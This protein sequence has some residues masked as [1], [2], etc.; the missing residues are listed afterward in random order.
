[1]SSSSA[2]RPRSLAVKARK[3]SSFSEIQ[4]GYSQL[5]S[6]SN[7]SILGIPNES[8]LDK[9]GLNLSVIQ[10]PAK[11]KVQNMRPNDARRYLNTK[12][13]YSDYPI[14]SSF[15]KYS[16]AGCSFWDM[17]ISRSQSTRT[18]RGFLPSSSTI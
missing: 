6:T 2:E 11:N 14:L 10:I 8:K 5:A 4:R 16:S 13:T 12:D 7:S 18:I 3:A 17:A 1:M 15:S 9:M